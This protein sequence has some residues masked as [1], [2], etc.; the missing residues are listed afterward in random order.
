MTL[1]IVVLAVVLAVTAGTCGVLAVRYRRVHRSVR[2]LLEGARPA[3]SPDLS[4]TPDPTT[5]EYGSIA[6]LLAETEAPRSDNLE[7]DDLNG[8]LDAVARRLHAL[9]GAAAARAEWM[10]RFSGAIARMAEGVVISDD[11]GEVIFRD[12]T[13]LATI[14]SRH[15]EALMDAA[16]HRLLSRA[17]EGATVREEV[18]LYGPPPRVFRLSASPLAGGALALV[19]DVTERERVE[20]LRRDF[21]ANI[22]HELRTPVG[23]ISL[24][25]ETLADLLADRAGADSQAAPTAENRTGED[26]TGE[27][28]ATILGLVGR[29]VAEADRMARVIDDLAELARVEH[30]TDA[31]R[32]V[33]AIQDVVHAVVERLANASEQ[34]GVA[35]HVAAPGDPILVNVDRRQIASAVHNLLDNAIKYSP[36]GASVS[37]RVRRSGPSAELSVQDSGIGIPQGDLPRIFERFY[38]VD[39]SRTASSGGIGLGL[40]IVRHVAINHGGD[41]AV[42]SME[43]EGSTFSLRLPL[44]AGPASTPQ[45]PQPTDAAS[46]RAAADAGAAGTAIHEAAPRGGSRAP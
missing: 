16:L 43:G 44:L 40:A 24:L 12:G 28:Q 8:V 19:E 2:R 14:P 45:Q 32:S 6:G 7:A 3:A 29:L 35:V 41:V 13:A 4:P 1:G 20:T 42:D 11:A 23:A 37:L 22:S 27:S 15:G 17:R 25:A 31:E 26:Q 46:P 34:F 9:A 21:V 39:R 30:E 5:A 18:R 33:V 10:G 38:R 36:A